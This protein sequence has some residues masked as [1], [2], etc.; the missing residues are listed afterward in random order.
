MSGRPPSRGFF[1]SE[2]PF[3]RLPLEPGFPTLRI[4]RRAVIWV[5]IIGLALLLIFVLKPLAT[6]YTDWLWFQ[7]LGFGNVF[8]VRVRAQIVTFIVFALIFWVIGAA[9]VLVALPPAG[10]G[11][12]RNRALA[13]RRHPGGPD[14]RQ[15]RGRPVADHPCLPP[16]EAVRDQGPDQ[17]E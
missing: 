4:S 3:S 16:P 5:V 9:N 1:D 12:P 8:G 6:L 15:Y 7:A 17:R 13:C 14:L 11:H 10:A 2:S